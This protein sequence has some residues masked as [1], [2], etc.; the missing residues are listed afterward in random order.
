MSAGNRA[1]APLSFED[2]YLFFFFLPPK[3][4]SR[5]SRSRFVFG[6]SPK[7]FPNSDSTAP[8][9]IPPTSGTNFGSDDITSLNHRYQTLPS[10]TSNVD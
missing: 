7:A 1:S 2:G 9:S 10:A 4:P 8:P 3:S 5:T 6:L